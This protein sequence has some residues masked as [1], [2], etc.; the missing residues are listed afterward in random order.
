MI[1]CD[2]TVIIV[3]IL[4]LTKKD[5]TKKDLPD[6]RFQNYDVNVKKIKNGLF[7]CTK[8]EYLYVLSG[9]LI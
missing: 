1:T 2:Y 9:Q 7:W 4:P 6:E 5:H 3:L 8:V